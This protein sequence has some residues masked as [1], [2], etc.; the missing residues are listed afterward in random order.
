MLYDYFQHVKLYLSFL[1][2]YLGQISHLDLG[3][4]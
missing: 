2:S 3:I 4:L 1:H